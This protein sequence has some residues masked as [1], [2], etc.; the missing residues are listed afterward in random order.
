MFF[1]RRTATSKLLGLIA[2]AVLAIGAPLPALAV[3]TCPATGALC[4]DESVEGATPTITTPPGVTSTTPVPIAGVVGEAWTFTVSVPGSTSVRTVG[5]FG[6][7][8]P[9]SQS[10]SD[11]VLITDSSSGSG[12]VNFFFSLYSDNELGQIGHVCDFCTA[13]EDGTFQQLSFLIFGTDTNTTNDFHVFLKSDV[14]PVPEPASLVL[15]GTALVGFGV[16]RRRHPSR[17][18]HRVTA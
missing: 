17:A 5:A 12:A 2:L 8:E 18:P 13:I 1:A 7:L 4:I 16:M 11:V 6:L 3:P 10:V 14:E 9:D 15:F